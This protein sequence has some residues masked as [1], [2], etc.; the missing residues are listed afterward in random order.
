MQVEREADRRGEVRTA[1][2]RR[3]L[4]I[5]DDREILELLAEWLRGRG[6]EVRT[7]VDGTCAVV[8]ARSFRPHVVV[9][10][11]VL[12][13]TTGVAVARRLRE[14]NLGCGIVFLSGLSRTELPPS[15]VVLEKPID[16]SALEHAILTVS[17]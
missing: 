10:D 2:R 3:V 14:E 13:G 12:R 9:L 8:E 15:E 1:H 16:L 6:H 7:L 11:G 17:G 5:D 4:L